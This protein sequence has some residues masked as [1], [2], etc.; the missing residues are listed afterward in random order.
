MSSRL[1]ALLMCLSAVAQA[2]SDP[3][4]E[5]AMRTWGAAFDARSGKKPEKIDAVAVAAAR[6]AMSEADRTIVDCAMQDLGLAPAKAGVCEASDALGAAKGI[7]VLGEVPPDQRLVISMEECAELSTCGRECTGYLRNFASISPDERLALRPCA[8]VAPVVATADPAP[9]KL[10]A[11][12]K[13]IDA[14]LRATAEKLLPLLPP[15]DQARVKAA[16]P[17]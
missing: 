5:L 2:K 16:L 15:A 12:Q 9:V 4:H 8:D 11:L 6:S 14:R 7:P 3:A 10:A 1:L 13:W 17:R